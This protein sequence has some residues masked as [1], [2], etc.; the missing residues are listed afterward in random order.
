MQPSICG[1][2]LKAP[3]LDPRMDTI[4]LSVF[5]SLFLCLWLS[6]LLLLSS[7]WLLCSGEQFLHSCPPGLLS[8]V[9][10]KL[11]RT[12]KIKK[13]SN[14]Q[15][16]LSAICHLPLVCYPTPLS[17]VVWQLLSHSLKQRLSTWGRNAASTGSTGGS[18]SP[19]RGAG[20]H[21][22]GI[23]TWKSLLLERFGK[24]WS[25]GWASKS[26]F[27]WITTITLFG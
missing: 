10:L 23:S 11:F 8:S 17:Y 20:C 14:P 27:N 1:P 25:L 3:V 18:S 4:H 21:K 7:L 13:K 15:I 24:P 19:H 6:S 26:F 5:L 9:S 16:F 2:R 22:G 12:R